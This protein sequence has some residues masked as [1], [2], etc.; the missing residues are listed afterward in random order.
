MAKKRTEPDR[1]SSPTAAA[2]QKLSTDAK[3]KPAARPRRSTAPRKHTEAAAGAPM[4]PLQRQRMIAEAAYFLAEQRGFDPGSELDD[5][6]QAELLVDTRG[7][8]PRH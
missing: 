7:G 4:T 6:L 3:P 1:T 8:Q 2:S 5:W